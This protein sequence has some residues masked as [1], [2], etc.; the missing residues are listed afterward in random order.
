M[1]LCGTVNSIEVAPVTHSLG[2]H[3]RHSTV[4]EEATVPLAPGNAHHLLTVA[5]PSS[6]PCSEEWGGTYS[7]SYS[8]GSTKRS[9]GSKPACLKIKR[10]GGAVTSQQVNK[11]VAARPNELFDF[12]DPQDGKRELTPIVF[13]D[14]HIHAT[15]RTCT[16][17]CTPRNEHM[18]TC[19]HTQRHTH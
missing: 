12:M 7:L 11:V 15:T 19:V 13:L 17:T 4:G 2:S 3:L 18:Y 6:R 1:Q 10:A 16:T 8:G 5:P 14:L 9:P